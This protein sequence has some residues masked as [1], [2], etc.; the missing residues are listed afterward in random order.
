MNGKSLASAYHSA[1]DQLRSQA[2]RVPPLLFDAG[3]VL[4]LGL[5]LHRYALT[6]PEAYE[7]Q[8]AESLTL[9]PRGFRLLPRRRR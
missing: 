4:A 9:K 1:M 5:I 6:A 2:G 3:L 8:I 7:L